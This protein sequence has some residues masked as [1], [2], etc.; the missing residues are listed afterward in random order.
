M[1]WIA[2]PSQDYMHG[3]FGLICLVSDADSSGYGQ[4]ATL[5]RVVCKWLRAA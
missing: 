2:M 5:V 4:M 3:Y 1:L